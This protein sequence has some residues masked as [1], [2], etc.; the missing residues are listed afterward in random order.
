[1]AMGKWHPTGLAAVFRRS[2]PMR[3]R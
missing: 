3:G 2:K 1:M